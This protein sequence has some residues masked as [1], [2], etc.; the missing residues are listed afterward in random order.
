MAFELGNSLMVFAF[1][2]GA[3]AAVSSILFW[4]FIVVLIVKAVQKRPKTGAAVGSGVFGGLWVVF[5]V[6][7]F[8][9]GTQS[10][11]KGDPIADKVLEGAGTATA[12][13]AAR[14]AESVKKGWSK[15]LLS[16][17]DKLS[18]SFVSIREIGEDERDLFDFADTNGKK[19]FEI[20]LAVENPLDGSK[21]IS[22]RKIN[23]EQ[24]IFGRDAD[25]NYI[26]VFIIDDS[27][28]STIP[29]ILTFF[30]P[31]YRKDRASTFIPIGKS[32][33]RLR[34]DVVDRDSIEKIIFGNKE[35]PI[36]HTKNAD[37][38]APQSA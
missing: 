7:A 9:L 11:I 12:N 27:G 8:V 17:I 20:L 23:K 34:F 22:Y 4:I 25:G 31:T 38:N 35:I 13:I 19:I 6:L 2:F 28:L 5:N 15:V 32:E 10:F 33:L 30:L 26:P 3:L 21:K 18:V 24:L 16:K 37:D 1:V 14:S 36:P 29:W